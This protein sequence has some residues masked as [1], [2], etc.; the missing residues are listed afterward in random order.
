ML[1]GTQIYKLYTAQSLINSVRIDLMPDDGDRDN[2]DEQDLSEIDNL[3]DEFIN[4]Y[5]RGED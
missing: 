2:E 5:G 4:R 1:T 3:I